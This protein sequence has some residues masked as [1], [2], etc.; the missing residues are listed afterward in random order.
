MTSLLETFLS[1]PLAGNLMPG[2]HSEGG[3][4]RQMG[5]LTPSRCSAS[6]HTRFLDGP[7]R[8]GC[9]GA[10]SPG[11]GGVRVFRTPRPHALSVYSF[12]KPLAAVRGAGWEQSSVPGRQDPIPAPGWGRSGE[13]WT[14]MAGGEL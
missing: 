8:G 13:K 11:E 3:R 9:V 1:K 7:S 10:G 12:Q 4:D 6:H 14:E 2:R 5:V